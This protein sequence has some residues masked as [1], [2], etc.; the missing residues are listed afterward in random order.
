MNPL[1]GRALVR[2]S[3]SFGG[4]TRPAV[5]AGGGVLTAKVRKRP[6]YLAGSSHPNWQGGKTSHPLYSMYFGML[7][8]CYLPTHSVF[9]HYGGRGITVCER[10]RGRN[11]FWR[12]VEDM[13]PRPPGLTIDRVDN[14]GPY[15]PG[16]CRWA[17][18]AQ[19]NA[20]QRPRRWNN[21]QTEQRVRELRAAGR[22]QR[23]IA[24][25]VGCSQG[26]V[27]HILKRTR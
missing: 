8:R 19:Q 26:T 14:D 1:T 24:D 2:R 12:F 3:V 17:T 25:E 18:H 20:D 7:S 15:A 21:E 6:K 10:W 5:L 27:H 13:G 23:A 11:G 9:R 4:F 16:N 22:T